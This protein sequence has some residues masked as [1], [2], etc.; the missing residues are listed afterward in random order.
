MALHPARSPHVTGPAGRFTR[1]GLFAAAAGAAV[2]L[3][4]CSSPSDVSASSS[5]SASS[6]S[7]AS[8]VVGGSE[9]TEMSIMQNIYAELLR[10]AGYQVTVQP[11]GERAVYA[12][13]LE[14]GQ[15]DVVPEYAA[16]M[17]EYLNR[18]A[19]GENAPRIATNDVTTTVRAMTPLADA[20]G[21]TV[22]QPAKA[23]DA[24]GFYVTEEF[25]RKNGVTTLSQLAAL[26]QPVVLA[27]GDDCAKNTFCQPGLESTY[28]LKVSSLTGDAYGSASAKQKV[29]NG[30]ATV[31][32][33]G[34]TDGTLD[35]LGL[36]LLD[37]DKKLQAADN[38]VPVVNAQ[39]AGDP[40]IAAALNT[41]PGPDHRGPAELNVRVDGPRSR[42]GRRRLRQEQGPRRLSP[43]GRAGRCR[44][45]PTPQPRGAGSG[46]LAR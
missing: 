22:L 46:R 28:G 23:L 40:K 8:I 25:S 42:S 16:S 18:T 4:A 34:T 12:P 17:A 41:G 24:N 9:A 3:G 29:V 5:S 21:L 31:G 19:N 30:Q 20:A 32:E 26:G 15:V 27:A 43:C 1:R 11:A 39:D 38:L 44:V 2:V 37:D 33:T 7:G 10:D 45:V 14:S 36:V 6:A 13:A 35:A